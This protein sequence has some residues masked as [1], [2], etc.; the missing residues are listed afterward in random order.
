MSG[1]GAPP[2]RVRRGE[3]SAG[4]VE[5]LLSTARRTLRGPGFVR[6]LRTLSQLNQ[7]LELFGPWL[8]TGTPV[9]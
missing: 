6:G 9:A 1:D 3:K 7:E 4:G 5:A 2:L 8:A